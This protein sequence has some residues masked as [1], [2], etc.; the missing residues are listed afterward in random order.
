MHNYLLEILNLNKQLKKVFVIINDIFL[1][2]ISC[3]FTEIIIH[4]TFGPLPAA[5]IF[6]SVISIITTITILYISSFY[7]ILSRHFSIKNVSF[8]IC[9]LGLNIILLILISKTTSF[10]F[11]EIV[12]EL[13]YFNLNFIIQQ[14]I[15]LILLIIFSRII[16]LNLFEFTFKENKKFQTAI[17]Y[18]SEIDEIEISKNIKF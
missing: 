11:P 12:I 5:F 6:Y 3:L 17:I 8:L 1:I 16:F 2:V 4:L 13:R 18:G 9:V 7:R 10:Y 14:N 15:T